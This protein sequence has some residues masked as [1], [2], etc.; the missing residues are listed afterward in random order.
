MESMFINRKM[1]E[2]NGGDE[3]V[4]QNGFNN[5]LSFVIYSVIIFYIIYDWVIIVWEITGSFFTWLG[6]CTTERLYNKKF[7]KD[8]CYKISETF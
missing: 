6:Q 7:Q 1:G 4:E 8:F 3:W 2:T 5:N